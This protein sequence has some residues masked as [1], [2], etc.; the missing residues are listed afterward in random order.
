MRGIGPIRLGMQMDRCLFALASPLLASPLKRLQ[1]TTPA[2][3]LRCGPS[4]GCHHGGGQ[5]GAI[6]PPMATLYPIGR[7]SYAGLARLQLQHACAC[8]ASSERVLD[9]APKVAP[10]GCKATLG[11]YARLQLRLPATRRASA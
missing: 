4:L 9:L 1:A 10:M 8:M 11:A 7:A 3:A 2:G 6:L 5:R